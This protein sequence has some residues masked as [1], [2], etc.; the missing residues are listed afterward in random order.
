VRRLFLV[1]AGT[2]LLALLLAPSAL[3]QLT[4]VEPQSPNAEGIKDS[5]LFIS[6]FIVAIFVLVQGLLLLF[7]WQYRR[8]KRGRFEDGAQIHGATRLELAW[9][10]APA[11]ILAAIA[12]FVFVELPG[13]TNV[14]EAGARGDQIEVRVTGK[15]FFWQ[16]EYENGVVAVDHLRA[17][18]G[19]PV[20]LLVTAPDSDVIHSWWIPALGG[21]FDAIPG[22]TTETWFEAEEPGTYEGQCAELCG[23]AHARML[24]SV[25]VLE[26]AEFDTWLDERAATG[27]DL[28]QETYEGVCQKCHGE[29]G[30]GGIGPRI[31]GSP[32]LTDF[33]ELAQLVR[34]GRN[35]MPAVGADWSDEHIQALVD[36]LEESPPSGS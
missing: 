6:I 19:V 3:A 28:G 13:I 2:L 15:Q 10:V 29:N 36:Y 21:K 20:R 8:K 25:E 26:P 1:S 30:E 22:V 27:G 35:E 18:A 5:F 31:A 23:V 11:V 4:P 32:T 12:A 33:D 24:A 9:T 7:A 34:N 14:P 17:P 16:Y